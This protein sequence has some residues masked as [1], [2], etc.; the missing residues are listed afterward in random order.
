MKSDTEP[1]IIAV[2]NRAAEN[3]KQ[4]VDVVARRHQ[5]HQ[6]PCG[7]LQARRTPRRLPNLAVVGGTC[8]EHF[9]QVPEGSRPSDAIRKIAWQ[10]ASSI[11]CTIRREGAGETYTLRI[12]EQIE[13][14][15]QV[16]SG[17][18]SEK[19]KC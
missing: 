18:R 13:S 5:N 3:C 4:M 14:Q 11:I 16:R 1:A 12:V 7:E 9:V 8:G 6:V 2:R 19:Q 17:A 15:I 10:E